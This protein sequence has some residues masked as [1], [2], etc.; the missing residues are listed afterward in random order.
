MEDKERILVID[1]DES[2][3]TSLSLIFRAKGYDVE[4][5][6]T[7]REAIETAQAG[8]FNLALIDTRLSD[9]QGGEL[10]GPLREIN[11]DM[12]L[13]LVTGYASV[14]SVVQAMNQGASAFITKPLDADEALDRVGQALERQR[15]VVENRQLFEAAQ[16]ELAERRR[17]EQE[18]TQERYLLRTLLENIPDHIYFKDVESRF[19]RANRAMAEWFGMSDPS[20]MLGKTDSD[21]FAPD[22]ARKAR[23]DEEEVMRTGQPI[24]GVEERETWPND[25]ETWV[26]T[27]KM[28]L[29]DQDGRVIGTFG[30]SRD[31][32]EHKQAE[33]RLRESERRFRMLLDNVRLVAVG[34]DRDGM[35]AYANPFLLELTGYALDEVLGR[36]WFD[37]FIPERDRE[38]LKTVLLELLDAGSHSH[39]ENV[40]LTEQGTERLVAW[41]NTLLL[42]ESGVPIGTMSIGEDVTERMHVERELEQRA[43]QLALLNEIGR[44]IAA[45]LDL[46]SL[47]DRTTALVQERFDY[48]HV[49]LFLVDPDRRTLAMRSRA[50]SYARLFP[51][52]HRVMMGK[53]M[54][55]Y[56]GSHGQALVSN[57]VRDES[58]YVNP[59][60]DVLPTMSELS[61]PITVGSE[62]VGV[63][64][65]QSP[66]VQAFGES[67]VLAMETLADQIAVALRNARL[68]AQTQRRANELAFLNSA[69]Q[70]MVSSFELDKV[71][72]TSIQQATE[73]LGVEAGSLLLL[74]AASGDLVFEAAWGGGDSEGLP[75][76]RVPSGAGIAGWVAEHR[77][78]AVVHNVYQDERFY[79]RFDEATEGFVTRSI[80]C[81]PLIYRDRVIGVMQ[82]L[83]KLE[84][85]F[86]EEDQRLLEALASATAIA[87]EN[88]R[89]Y[90]EVQRE[91]GE[92]MR[93]EQTLRR[94]RASLAQRVAERTAEL[95]SA[96]AE[97]A[98]AARLKDEFLAS[99]SHELR[100]PLNAIL[101]LAEALQESVYGSL[102]DRQL[103]SLHR[104][105]DSGRHLLELINEVLDISKIEAGKLELQFAPVSVESVCQASIMLVR[106]MAQQ[107]RL[108]LSSTF[109]SRLTGIMADERRLKQ[110]LVNLL[111]NAC[112]FTPEGGKIGLDVSAD[113]EA[114]AVRFCVWDTGIGIA[115]EDMRRL[116][117]PFVQLDSSLSRRYGGTGLGLALVRRL[118]ELHGGGVS[119]ES[120]GIEG[121]GSRFTVS[122]PWRMVRHDRGSGVEPGQ[123]LQSPIAQDGVTHLHDAPLI[124]LA[125][126]HEDNITTVV[127]YLQSRG[128]RLSVARNGL[129]A[130]ARA[131]EER[132]D[133]ILMD[134]QMPQMDGLEAIQHIRSGEVPGMAEVPIVAVTALAMPGDRERCL[135]AGASAYISK[136][137]SLSKLVE[138]IDTQLR[139]GTEVES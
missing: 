103:Q 67:D 35:V 133:L 25:R 70:M 119:V 136:P 5:A 135:A 8:L 41:N 46:Q 95:S 81:V 24:I 87:V 53:G 29:Y 93:A 50:G 107:K 130:L 83:N 20:D 75:G 132:P 32:A 76:Q 30:V 114:E 91:L 9:M 110:I 98:R 54:V 131:V 113:A 15:L 123:S 73:V 122:L 118:T 38:N 13:I 52:Q 100:T 68:Y 26:S 71:L 105:E 84:G 125:E 117:E 77:C 92:R 21:Y 56:V 18:L 2:N 99:M 65:V 1:D 89:L 19:I 10:L 37:T 79:S 4:T 17:V 58:R 82:A 45:E 62:I 42:D 134:I 86:T 66:Q 28:P 34:L 7:G 126:D 57:D 139:S 80:L 64:D 106:E 60:P 108:T 6:A 109:D 121:Q 43:A 36:D 33:L 61:V 85:E 72:Q 63:L 16:R 112:K 88:A 27:T 97:L 48:H 104:I 120:T 96:N 129:E 116:F 55:G 94:E 49:A 22:H 44:Q 90:N 124:L 31:I 47:L 74:D 69:S 78:S 51:V 101:G 127:D 128:Y 102:N 11:P 59:Y 115:E 111:S 137:V 40:I 39:Y 12:V 23:A 138:L 14:E 3:R